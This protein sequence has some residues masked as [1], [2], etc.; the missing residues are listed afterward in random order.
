MF[1]YKNKRAITDIKIKSIT[2]AFHTTH[3]M[4]LQK[5][6][7]IIKIKIRKIL[8]AVKSPLSSYSKSS[9]LLLGKKKPKKKVKQKNQQNKN[10]KSQKPYTKNIHLLF[11][12]TLCSLQS[13]IE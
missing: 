6:I 5:A 3:H 10:P 13:N 7:K 11:L 2:I 8:S 1:G 12:K 4:T 9:F